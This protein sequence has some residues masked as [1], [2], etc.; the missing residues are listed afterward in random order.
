MREGYNQALA[1]KRNYIGFLM[2]LMQRLVVSSTSAI[3]TALE[4]RLEVLTTPHE[5]LS[6]PE[7]A[8]E[9]EWADLD[10]QE[11][12]DALLPACLEALKNEYDEVKLLLDAATSC[13]QAGP[14]AKAEALLD[15]IY[16]LQAE[17]GDPGLKVLVFTEFISTQE[18]L[19]RFLRERGF[20]VVC[21]NGSKDMEER[22]RV[23]ES[24]PKMPAFLFLPT[25]R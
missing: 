13:E 7:F 6:L 5:Q 23:Q 1:E 3:R 11:Q 18:M 2:I 10:G 15:W 24:L 22:G 17:E 9:D 8:S 14:D 20:S 19:R 21:L 12:V 16:R 25:P 4:K